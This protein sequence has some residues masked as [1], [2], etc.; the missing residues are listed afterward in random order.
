M[1]ISIVGLGW[2]GSPLASELKE[3]GHTIIG[4]TRTIEKKKNLDE[5]GFETFLLNYPDAPS[6]AVLN[7]DVVVLN[8][9]PFGDASKWFKSWPWKKETRVIFISS[10]SMYPRPDS[11]SALV[12]ADQ[13]KWLQETFFQWTILR[14]GG[15]LGNGRHPGK[16]LSGRKDLAGKNK[17]VNLIHLKDAVAFTKMAIDLKLDNRIFHVVSDDHRSREEFYTDYC[18]RHQLPLPTFDQNDK[19][20]GPVVPNQDMKEF[21]QPM[22]ILED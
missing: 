2:F 19:E 7:S 13:E 21:Y 14:F 1:K 15:L 20:E 16:I 17:P 5:K 12:L 4:T 11:L 6:E 3:A 8:I 10:T 9:P 22:L 18:K